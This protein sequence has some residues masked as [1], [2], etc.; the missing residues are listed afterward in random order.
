MGLYNETIVGK[1]YRGRL[2]GRDGTSTKPVNAHTRS[3]RFE[4]EAIVA[5]L[6][7]GGGVADAGL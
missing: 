7:A 1:P 3:L 4:E 2:W 5:L 6:Q